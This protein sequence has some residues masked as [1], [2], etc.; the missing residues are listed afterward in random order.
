MPTRYI[1][2]LTW[3]AADAC[4]ELARNRRQRRQVHVDGQRPHGRQRAE[5]EGDSNTGHRTGNGIIVGQM[6]YEREAGTGSFKIIAAS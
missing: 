5:D 2:R 6:A 1:A 3:T 4:T